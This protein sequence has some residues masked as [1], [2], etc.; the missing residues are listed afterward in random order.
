MAVLFICM[1]TAFAYLTG[2]GGT[3]CSGC[4]GAPIEVNARKLF[5][6]LDLL[7]EDEL[8]RNLSD[9]KLCETIDCYGL[10][11]DEAH[12]SVKNIIE[13][14]RFGESQK[15]T[16]QTLLQALY[17]SLGSIFIAMSSLCVAIFSWRLNVRNSKSKV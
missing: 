5:D 7:N 6:A 12:N 8:T 15:L 14:H 9:P 11:I 17:F 10:T 2:G 16:Q 1:P 4:G 13:K 3:G